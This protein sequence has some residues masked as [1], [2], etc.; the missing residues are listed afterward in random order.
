M[1]QLKTFKLNTSYL[2]PFKTER[3]RVLELGGDGTVQYSHD[4]FSTTAYRSLATVYTV[5]TSL[6][7]FPGSIATNRKRTTHSHKELY[8]VRAI[9]LILKI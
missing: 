7:D 6:R 8:S 9:F 4:K 3:H 1:P 5:Y 2:L